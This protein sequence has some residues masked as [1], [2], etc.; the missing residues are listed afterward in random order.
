MPKLVDSQLIIDIGKVLFI[1][2][3]DIKI[4]Y[5]SNIKL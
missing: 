1:S 5:T 2:Y 4:E 3:T